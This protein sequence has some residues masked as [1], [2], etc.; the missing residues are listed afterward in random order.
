MNG[1]VVEEIFA[2]YQAAVARMLIRQ[3]A[4][5]GAFVKS[6]ASLLGDKAKRLGEILLNEPVACLPGPSVPAI[7]DLRCAGI[8]CEG[9]LL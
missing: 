5:Y 6:L 1:L 8:I 4:G 9:G 2:R 3:E 7:E